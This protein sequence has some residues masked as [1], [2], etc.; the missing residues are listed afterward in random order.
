M[1]A[2]VI[3]PTRNRAA[4]ARNAISSLTDNKDVGVLVSDNST[5]GDAA[6]LERFC[7]A[8]G[9]DYIRPPAPLAMAAHW[10]WALEQALRQPATHFSFLTDR[11]IFKPGE[12]N[13]LLAI[14]A[15]YPDKI[16]CYMHDR[17]AD[18]ANPVRLEQAPWTGNIFEVQSAL[19]LSL[20]ANSVMYDCSAP[21]MLNS[22][23]PRSVLEEIKKTFGTVFSSIAPDWNFCFRSLATVQSVLFYDRACLVH[24]ASDQ[25]NGES[26]NR[27]LANSAHRDFIANLPQPLD[28]AAPLPHVHTVWNTIISEY[29]TVNAPGFPALDR[30]KYLQALAVG[31]GAIE[32]PDKRL[33][34]KAMLERE[35]WAGEL[36]RSVS[37]RSM[38]FPTTFEAIAY[39]IDHPRDPQENWPSSQPPTELKGSIPVEHPAPLPR[40]GA[41][42]WKI[43]S[44]LDRSLI[45]GPLRTMLERHLLWRL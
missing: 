11:M 38:S 35:G 1:Q 42:K 6:I 36:P 34:M 25:S 5:D 45:A 16:I 4:I 30:G 24:Y 9:V 7:A 28:H 44:A 23:V 32:D 14:A 20:V 33:A 37:P 26:Q 3:V 39:S 19:I 21:R 29:F 15:R 18:H 43:T 31:V 40:A 12:L 17:I 10:D 8:A 22:I 41:L 27:G 2:L 13:T